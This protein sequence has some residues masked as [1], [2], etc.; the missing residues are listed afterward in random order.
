MMLVDE[1]MK[2]LTWVKD[3]NGFYHQGRDLPTLEA[4]MRKA[5]PKE[6]AQM[7]AE[8]KEIKEK[9]SLYETSHP[10]LPD[11]SEQIKDVVNKIKRASTRLQVELFAHQLNGFIINIQ[12]KLH[13]KPAKIGKGYVSVQDTSGILTSFNANISKVTGL[14]IK[15]ED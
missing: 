13:E 11:W 8:K 12:D 10:V 4:I 14:S 9:A 1:E 5:H 6:A 15:K 2:E 3:N 7:D